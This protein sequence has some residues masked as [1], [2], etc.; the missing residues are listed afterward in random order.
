MPIRLDLHEDPAVIGISH[1]VKLDRLAVVGRLILVWSWASRQSTDGHIPFATR[2][3]VDRVAE[4]EGFAEAMN[5]VGWIN[6]TPAGGITVPNFDRWLGESAKKR[7]ELSRRV[8]KTRYQNVT[9]K[10]YNLSLSMSSHSSSGNEIGGAGERKGGAE[11]D[12]AS[13]VS[14]HASVGS[15]EWF[16]DWAARHALRFSFRRPDDP[17]T[18]AGWWLILSKIEPTKDELEKA[19]LALAESDKQTKGRPEHPKLLKSI[20]LASRKSAPTPARILG[21]VRTDAEFEEIKRKLA[22]HR[23]QRKTWG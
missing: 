14:R 23:E 4:R 17:A 9:K 6:E 12:F 16:A 3:D 8:S 15:P 13:E 11:N 21:P 5:A 10:C 19:S 22:I 1:L 20:V 2:K 18:L 7:L